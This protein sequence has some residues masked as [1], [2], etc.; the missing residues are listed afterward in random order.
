M[1]RVKPLRTTKNGLR[2]SAHSTKPPTAAEKARFIAMRALGC[3]A[4]RINRESGRASAALT[5]RN[6]EIHHLLSGGRRIGH[7]ATVCLCHFH[8]QGKRLPYVQYG[9][10]AQA[11]VFG[12]SLAREPRRFHEMYGTDAELLDRQNRL[13][14]ARARNSNPETT[15]A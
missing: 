4:C 5:R 9:Y 11:E 14:A 1:R 3:I 2:R 7:E 10:S 13:L 15:T 8:H 6:L 12:P